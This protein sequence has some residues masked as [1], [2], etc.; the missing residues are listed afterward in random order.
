[1]KDGDILTVG[2]LQ[3]RILIMFGSGGLLRQTVQEDQ[4]RWLMESCPDSLEV[5]SG[6]DTVVIEIPPCL[7]QVDD[8][9]APENGSSQDDAETQTEKC[10]S[11]VLSAGEYLR[12]YFRRQ[13]EENNR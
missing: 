8:E 7:L 5:D 9:Q 13:S 2:P 1:M 3:F 12:E 11:A 6:A 10:D 4:V